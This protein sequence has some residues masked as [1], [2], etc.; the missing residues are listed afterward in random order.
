MVV[1]APKDYAREPPRGWSSKWSWTTLDGDDRAQTGADARKLF[2]EPQFHKRA[3]IGDLLGVRAMLD[4][5]TVDVDDVDAGGR[6][7]LHFAVGFGREHV[8]RELLDR[9]AA[10]ETRDDWGKAPVDFAMQ[11]LHDECIQMLRME[12]VKRGDWGGR[13]RVAPL[14]TYYEY[15]YNLT[16]EEVHAQIEKH[17]RE[18]S[19]NYTRQAKAD[20]AS[21]NEQRAELQRAK[22]K[23]AI[24]EKARGRRRR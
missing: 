6:T 11:G 5:R 4:A 17:A 12:A 1:K 7:A 16:N 15:A 19:E 18:A 14:K 10:L 20:S 2:E 23:E 9:G 8:A 3:R 13:G 21:Y 24:K 22:V